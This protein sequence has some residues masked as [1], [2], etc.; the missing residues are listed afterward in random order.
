MANKVK[1]TKTTSVKT[2][3]KPEQTQNKGGLTGIKLG[4]I[5]MVLSLLTGFGGVI[6]F[7]LTITQIKVFPPA[8]V[9]LLFF[10]AI[11]LF[12]TALLV[13]GSELTR[14]GEL[15]I[16]KIKAEEARKTIEKLNNNPSFAKYG[17]MAKQKHNPKK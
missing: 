14:N 10:L 16:N 9:V 3:S 7:I 2:S 12:T 1:P 6:T 5:L 13:V 15:D 4:R 11:G 17:E 8:I